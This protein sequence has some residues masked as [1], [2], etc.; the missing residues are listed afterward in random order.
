MEDYKSDKIKDPSLKIDFTDQATNKIIE[1]A[2]KFNFSPQDI[3][4][5]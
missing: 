5:F 4:V 2:G 1:N 3:Q